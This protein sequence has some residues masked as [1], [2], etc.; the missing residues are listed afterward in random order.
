MSTPARLP[1]DTRPSAFDSAF[2]NNFPMY[3]SNAMSPDSTGLDWQSQHNEAVVTHFGQITPPDDGDVKVLA[4]TASSVYPSAYPSAHPAAPASKIFSAKSERARNAANQRHS[5]AKKAR[6]DSFKVEEDGNVDTN[7]VEGKREKYREKNRLAAAKCRQKKKMN[8]DDLEQSA[9]AVTGQN[10]RLRAEERELRDLFS[11]LR[12]QALAHDPSQGCNCQTI[13]AYNLNKAHETARA[14]MGFMP[15]M[16]PSPVQRSLDSASPS[17]GGTTSRTQSFSGVRPQFAQHQRR[18][19]SIGN[20]M[21]FAPQ[22]P[23]GGAMRHASITGDTTQSP[24]AFT[25]ATHVHEPSSLMPEEVDGGEEHV[26]DM[27]E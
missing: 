25:A 4:N 3:E 17:T 2:M 11:S 26:Q 14:T 6:K 12:D 10:N 7:E 18:Q 5:K 27:S 19:Q 21:A 22:E 16:M 8:T 24:F 15:G 1:A 13:H 20:S 9:R 23:K